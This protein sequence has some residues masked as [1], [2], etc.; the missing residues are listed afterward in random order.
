MTKAGCGATKSCYSDHASCRSSSDCRFL[1]TYSV[2]GDNVII[3]LS[4]TAGYVAIG[5]GNNN[6]MVNVQPTCYKLALFFIFEKINVKIAFYSCK[7]QQ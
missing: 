3:S 5:F 6:R 1:A 7:L 4:A 2:D